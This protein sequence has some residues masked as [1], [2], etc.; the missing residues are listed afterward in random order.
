[1]N[2]WSRPGYLA[3]TA[4][5]LMAGAL[6]AGTLRLADPPEL[7]LAVSLA[8]ALQ[9]PSYWRLEG[10]LRRGARI[11]GAWVGGMA[12]RLAG[13]PLLAIVG[14]EATFS[15]S[16]L[17]VTYVSALLVLLFLEALWLHRWSVRG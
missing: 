9:A 1:M 3:V 4:A 12:A 11:M 2:P 7:A 5:L 15:R 8:W 17:L 13:V 16:S 6:V 14:S 10:L